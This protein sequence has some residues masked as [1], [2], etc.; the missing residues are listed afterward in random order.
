MF[1]FS[2]E[3]KKTIYI[4]AM[5]FLSYLAVYFA[6]NILGA[7][8]PHM[9]E[10]GIFTTEQIGTLS[11]VYFIVYAIGQLLNGM[12]GDKFKAKYML[13][14]G[15][16]CAGICNAAFPLFHDHIVII[17]ITYG[18][19]GFFLSMIYGPMAKI[20]AENLEGIYAT[21]CSVGYSFA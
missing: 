20:I 9:L 2:N 13:G 21:R 18:M 8:T 10:D 16:A 15:L 1:K 5:C 14:L 17:Y 19:V 12:I 3:A 11:S 7:V 4:G 6:R